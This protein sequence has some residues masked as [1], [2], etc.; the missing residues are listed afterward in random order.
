MQRDIIIR[1]GIQELIIATDNDKMGEKLRKEVAKSLSGYV[2]IKHAYIR[3][4]KDA[5]EILVKE[6]VEALRE[7]VAKAETS[8]S[9]FVNLRTSGRG[10]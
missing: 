9:M 8:R 6:G 10:R 4:A 7:A 1:S 2:R 3:G 5:N